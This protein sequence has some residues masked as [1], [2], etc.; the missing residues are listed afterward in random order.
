MLSNIKSLFII[1]FICLPNVHCMAAKDIP[2]TIY[3]K[4]VKVVDGDTIHIS[5]KKYG[6]LKIR[7]AEIDAPEKDQPYGK[8]ATARL[9]KILTNKTIRLNKITVDRYNRIIGIVYYENIDINHYLV[10]N[11]LAWCYDYYNKREKIKDAEI[12][13]RKKEIGI[14]SD[15]NNEAIPPW[16]WRKNKRLKNG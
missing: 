7:L 5:H 15:K 12:Y 9:S 4:V 11:G 3:A 2:N 16:E 1:I 10:I 8:E 6:L 13:A 14:W